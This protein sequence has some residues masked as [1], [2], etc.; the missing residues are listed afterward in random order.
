MDPRGGRWTAPGVFHAPTPVP[1]Q[2]RS[3]RDTL[4]L[5][6]AAGAP[7]SHDPRGLKAAEA[8]ERIRADCLD[9]DHG[10]VILDLAADVAGDL[11]IADVS[12]V[13]LGIASPLSL[14]SPA[15]LALSISQPPPERPRRCGG[16]SAAEMA[17]GWAGY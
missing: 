10:I 11:P 13:F 15:L 17:P 16:P 7:R 2:L 5:T 9:V 8:P 14:P 6:S 3:S 4:G 12:R 1:T